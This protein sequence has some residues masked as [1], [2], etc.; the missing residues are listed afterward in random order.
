MLVQSLVLTDEARL[1]GKNESK[2]IEE[3][4]MSFLLL[5]LVTDGYFGD[6]EI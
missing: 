2:E 1:R 6:S 4:I 5:F 3:K